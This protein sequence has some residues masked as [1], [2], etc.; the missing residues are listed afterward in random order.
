[1]NS[2]MS[3]GTQ[4]RMS[5]YKVFANPDFGSSILQSMVDSLN[6]PR[7]KQCAHCTGSGLLTLRIVC[8]SCKGYGRTA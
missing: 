7:V 8:T 4:T 2:F 1:M 6:Q 3:L 5:T